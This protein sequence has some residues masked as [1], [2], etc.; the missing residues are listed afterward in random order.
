MKTNMKKK[1]FPIFIMLIFLA[2]C[3]K[4]E[5]VVE[6]VPQTKYVTT[7]YIEEKPF[8]EQIKLPWKISASKE[9]SIS[10]LASWIINSINVNVWDKVVAWQVLATVDT[11]S[12]LSWIN[13][14][15]AV[16]SYNNA[17]AVYNSTKVSLEKT[18]ETA[19]IQ[20]DN[21]KIWRDNTYTSTEKQLELAKA[22]L[23]AVLTQKWNTSSSSTTSLELAEKSLENSKLNL[24]NFIKNSEE[25]LKSLESKKES[26]IKNMRVAIEWSDVLFE[27]TLTEIDKI[28]WVTDLNKNYNDAFEIYLAA[29]NNSLKLEAINL[30]TKNNQNYKTI[31]DGYKLDFSEKELIDYMN[32]IIVESTNNIAMLDKMTQVLNNSVTS[33]SFTDLTLWNMKNLI[34]SSQTQFTNLKGN[35]TTLN[36]TYVDTIN[37]INS[38]NTNLVTQRATLEQAIKVAQATYDN[39]K[40]NVNTGLDT[41][42]SSEK[43]TRIQYES[44]VESVKAA[45][46]TADNNLKMAENQLTSAQANY[47]A[48]LVSLKSQVDSASG[49]KN[50]LWQQIANSE[51]KAPY[52]GIVISRNIEIWSTV[53]QWAVAF[54]LA[55]SNEKV[56]KMDVNSENIKYLPIWQETTI[57]RNNLKSNGIISLVWAWAVWNSMYPIEIR[58]IDENF[59]SSVV[60]W[61]FVDVFIQKDIGEEKYI[62]IPFSS[63]IVGG[64]WLYYVYVVW[65]NDKVEERKVDIWASN[66]NEVII[67]SWLEVWDRLIINWALNVSVGDKVEEK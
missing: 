10:S 32:S 63:I 15:N 23:D 4:E 36:N 42:D 21:A 5:V 3:W 17:L 46:E 43:T 41:V 29:K 28:L 1:I 64:S 56:V 33:D 66:S 18:L 38:T 30:F 14:S 54:T 50:T 22:Q 62:V 51:I 20:Y 45:R 12:N 26:L 65:E 25:T 13:M 57:S 2:W 31:K 6:E 61:D 11:T 19:K 40:A 8:W 39:T 35:L 44:T 48:Q 24:D 53:W 34:N 47:D 9:T 27:S 60:L 59:S 37:S 55:N 67:N 7:E 58:I 49:Q 16:T 52:D